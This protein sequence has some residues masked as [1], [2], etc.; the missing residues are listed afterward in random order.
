[1]GK[2]IYLNDKNNL[3]YFDVPYNFIIGENLNLDNWPNELF[4][5]SLQIQQISRFDHLQTNIDM[6]GLRRY[7]E[8]NL[9]G[10]VAV[11]LHMKS[12]L[13]FLFFEK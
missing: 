2:F 11:Y 6:V 7:I 9:K 12:T 1:M 3:S 4:P 8:Q 10:D 13:N 5:Y